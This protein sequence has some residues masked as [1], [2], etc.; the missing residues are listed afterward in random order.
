MLHLQG[1]RARKKAALTGL[2]HG[3]AALGVSRRRSAV[4]PTERSAQSWFRQVWAQLS[5]LAHARCSM[6]G[7]RMTIY[8][9]AHALSGVE[10]CCARGRG[11]GDVCRRVQGL[12]DL[13][14]HSMGVLGARCRLC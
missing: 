2:L 9:S 4:P 1:A 10:A 7:A 5:A 14:H 13:A 8:L 6:H 12:S 11:P 3:L